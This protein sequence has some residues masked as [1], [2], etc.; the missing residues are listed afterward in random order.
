MLDSL[1]FVDDVA[2]LTEMLSILLLAFE[3]MNQETKSLPPS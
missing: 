3:I 1:D 2:L